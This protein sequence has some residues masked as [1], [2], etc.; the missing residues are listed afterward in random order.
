ME[1][2]MPMM[3]KTL[4]Q[5]KTVPTWV[6]VLD[7]APTAVMFLLGSALVWKVSPTFS[8][9]FL[10][11]CILSIFMFWY[12]ICPW[13]HHFGT[14][15]CPCGYGTISSRIFERRTGKEFK[16]V[17]RRNIGIVFPCWIIPFG[18]GIYLLWT[19]FSWGLFS[20]FLSFCIVGFAL[21]PALSKFI[22]CRWCTTRDECPWMSPAETGHGQ[23]ANS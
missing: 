15:G 10:V 23:Q 22:G 4:E 8:V 20:L 6:V 7:N 18:T 14:S 5:E 13:C 2:C 19:G 21:I 16:R 1:V 11:Y 12:L 17:F 3:G 9:L